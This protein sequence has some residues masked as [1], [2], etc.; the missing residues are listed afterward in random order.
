MNNSIKDD[1]TTIVNNGE[2]WVRDMT[3]Y[4]FEHSV[5]NEDQTPPLNTELPL[6]SIDDYRKISNTLLKEVDR[7]HERVLYLDFTPDQGDSG[8]K[9][10]H[11]DVQMKDMIMTTCLH[12]KIQNIEGA[13][14]NI[15]YLDR[16]VVATNGLKVSERFNLEY[17]HHAKQL[18]SGVLITHVDEES[19]LSLKLL[20]VES[21]FRNPTHGPKL[22]MIQGH[23]GFQ[24]DTHT[25]SL[26][27]ALQATAYKELDEEVCMNTVYGAESISKHVSMEQLRLKYMIYDEMDIVSR[28]HIG[29][30][31][32]LEIEDRDLFDS[33]ITNEP[34]KHSVETLECGKDGSCGLDSWLELVMKALL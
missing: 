19:G 24:T 23:V 15:S 28:E 27:Q 30:I 9:M 32:T 3:K 4:I 13:E 18:I 2:E 17:N 6:S 33:I 22:T 14:D 29:Y 25:K 5:L 21:D 20:R 16:A 26:Y 12:H 31:F 1:Q 8:Y 34:E 11:L 7:Y 10:D